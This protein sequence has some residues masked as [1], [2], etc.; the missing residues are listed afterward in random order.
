MET[1]LMRNVYWIFFGVIDEFGDWSGDVNFFA[2]TWDII[3][4]YAEHLDNIYS[5]TNRILL[6]GMIL[7]FYLI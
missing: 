2:Q 3:N 7:S 5:F 1:C 4:R 6:E